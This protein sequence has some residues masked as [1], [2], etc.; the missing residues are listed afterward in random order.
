MSERKVRVLVADD[1]A[2]VRLFIK[3]VIT[4][5]GWEVVAEAGNGQQAVQ[6]F[7]RT[8]P[9]L[10]L[11]D[12]NMPV[13]DGLT[14][15]KELRQRSESAAIVMLTSLASMEVVERCL[16]AG[17]DYHLRKDLPVADLK[18][19]LLD[20]WQAHADPGGEE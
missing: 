5:L 18:Q 7:E 12:I 2:H 15:L 4:S 20:A 13:M 1:E 14:A 17:A 6:H 16:E 9:D 10:V 8:T 3:T 11:L 19:E